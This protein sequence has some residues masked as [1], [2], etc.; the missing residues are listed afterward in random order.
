VQLVSAEMVAAVSAAAV[1][2]AAYSAG[3]DAIPAAVVTVTAAALGVLQP[4]AAALFWSEAVG[5]VQR[6]WLT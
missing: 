1:A 4:A 3:R 5:T 6:P 2:A